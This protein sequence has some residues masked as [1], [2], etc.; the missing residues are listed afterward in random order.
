MVCIPWRKYKKGTVDLD[1]QKKGI[2]GANSESPLVVEDIEKQDVVSLAALDDYDESKQEDLNAS[3]QNTFQL[4]KFMSQYSQFTSFLQCTLDV[5]PTRRPTAWLLH[6]IEEIYDERYKA[7]FSQY[8]EGEA[9]K[10]YLS[11][12]VPQAFQGVGG[13]EG[14][15]SAPPSISTS[16]FVYRYLLKSLGLKSLVDQTCWDLLYNVSIL[17]ETLREV[18]IFSMYLR[19]I[20]D[21]NV[22]IFMLFC[23]NT[24]QKVFPVQ[25][26]LRYKVIEHIPQNHIPSSALTTRD[27]PCNLHDQ[28]VL[29]LS[30]WAC[31]KIF[32]VIFDKKKDLTEYLLYKLRDKF[33][34][35]FLQKMVGYLEHKRLRIYL[36]LSQINMQK[37]WTKRPLR[38]YN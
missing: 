6:L 15:D 26:K 32:F 14:E 18:E 12:L 2:E 16:T 4:S 20:W 33:T 36:R 34:P 9:P 29:Y 22:L 17:Q 28:K 3:S 1:K 7:E 8:N 38:I 37:M 13:H 31:E 11:A 21:E 25:L 10:Y 23:R 24:I 5:K 19:E 30:N 35:P 27:H